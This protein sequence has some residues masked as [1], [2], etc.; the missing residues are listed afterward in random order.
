M[1][2]DKHAGHGASDHDGDEPVD[3]LGLAERLAKEGAALY[4]KFA[5]GDRAFIA[6]LD[7]RDPLSKY[8]SQSNVRKLWA[9]MLH[10]PLSYRGEEYQYRT[11]DGSNNNILHPDLGKAGLP[12]AKS[13]PGKG[14]MQGARPDPGDLFDLLMARKDDR[15]SGSGISSML[16]YH[17]SI[18]IHDIFRTN[19]VDKD[20]SDTS[21]Y[22]DLSPLYGY[23]K[24]SQETVRSKDPNCPGFLKPDTFAD[25]RLLLQPPGVCIYLIMYNRFHNHVAE[26]LL[27]INENGK[28]SLPP[29]AKGKKANDPELLQM[30]KKQDEDLFQT[31]R[32]SVLT[33]KLVSK[34]TDIL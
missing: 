21:S 29:S 24:A 4:Q 5:S 32:L 23:D 19:S 18:I 25:R 10:P 16:L 14:G 8:L 28:F 22:L 20:I 1:V 30:L 9:P 6:T 11:A 26:Q 31:A 15:Q 7:V 3:T 33:S 2:F 17:A 34:Y 12:Y 27:S 13:V